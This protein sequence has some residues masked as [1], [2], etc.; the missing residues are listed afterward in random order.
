[1][2]ALRRKNLLVLLLIGFS[3]ILYACNDSDVEN[4]EN[5]V[6]DEVTSVSLDSGA[7]IVGENGTYKNYDLKG[8]KFV[9]LGLDETIV[10]YNK[11]TGNY[12]FLKDGKH[13]VKYDKEI[14]PIED[15]NY[16]FLKLSNDGQYLAYMVN[17]EGYKLKVLDL[18]N[19][20]TEFVK[21]K[22][23]ISGKLFDFMDKSTLVY[24][25]IG[26]DKTN[27]IFTYDLRSGEE[28]LLYKLDGGY[29]EYLKGFND[30]VIV[31]QQTLDNKKVLK[32]IDKEGNEKILS[33]DIDM[34]KDVVK[35]GNEYFI[36]GQF[37]G[38][39]KSLYQLNSDKTYS[40][41]VYDFP[42]GIDLDKGL[43]LDK[44]GNILFVG[45][46]NYGKQSVFSYDKDG[47]VILLFD[48]KNDY[49]FVK[50]N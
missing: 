41:L 1:M 8:Q 45:I 44:K 16:N 6:S 49:T 46:D 17:D 2:K 34:I 11:S 39:N 4:S 32:E 47:N 35:K 22:A 12:V 28:K 37:L 20:K 38:D 7:L 36:L 29:I 27:G 18:K 24:Y 48:G 33:E 19:K 23:S 5:S 13:F 9:D 3:T 40:R 26:S 14:I 42:K 21:E 10:E 50:V 31:F 43:C 30:G 15:E 25:G